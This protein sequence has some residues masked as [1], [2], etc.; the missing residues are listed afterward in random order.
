[1]ASI[2]KMILLNAVVADEMTQALIAR[3]RNRQAYWAEARQLLVGVQGGTI[4]R[5][6]ALCVE[7]GGGERSA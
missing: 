2:D 1:M 6:A 3:K 7:A 4:P 5:R